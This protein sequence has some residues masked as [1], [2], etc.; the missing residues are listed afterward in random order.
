MPAHTVS[1]LEDILGEYVKPGGSFTAA[2]SQ[3]LPRLYEMGLWRDTTYETS[4]DGQHGYV[5]LPHDTD[6]VIA[7]TVNNYPRPVRSMW[8]DVRIVGRQAAVSALFGIVDDGYKPVQI[9]ML[10]VQGLDLIADVVPADR[11]DLVTPG[12]T[13]SPADLSCTITVETDDSTGAPDQKTD[14]AY[15][16][17]QFRIDPANTF[18]EIKSIRYYDVPVPLNLIDPDFPTK[19]IAQIPVGTGTV[20]Y[21]RFRAAQ[22]NGTD[23]VHLLVKRSAPSDL[24]PDTVVHLGSTAAIKYGLLALIAE[25][26][27]DYEK[28]KFCWGEAE[29]ILDKELESITGAA[30]P[31]IQIDLSG[32]GAAMP[33]GNFM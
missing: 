3:V 30:K 27:T 7:A 25:D 29:G 14:A 20:R 6:A 21:R 16:T 2:L 18:S 12:G 10:D 33:I 28:S 1:Q 22:R 11:L 15:V 17:T 32:G 4:L 19:V 26:N 31:S 5:S 24:Q 9:E 8:H 13:V 23:T